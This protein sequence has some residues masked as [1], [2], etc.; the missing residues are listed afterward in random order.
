MPTIAA[1][2]YETSTSVSAKSCIEV[3]FQTLLNILRNIQK[4]P[5]KVLDMEEGKAIT[6]INHHRCI[7]V[8]GL[9]SPQL[10]KRLVSKLPSC[11]SVGVYLTQAVG[12]KN[13]YHMILSH[14]TIT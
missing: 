6:C 3:W 2:S 11:L 12:Q 8:T 5:D 10:T 9:L 14:D 13:T 1:G 7:M 4:K